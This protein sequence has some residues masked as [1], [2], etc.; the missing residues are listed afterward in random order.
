MKKAI[1]L[2]S[3]GLIGTQ[4]TQL[5]IADKRYSEIIILVRKKTSVVH[6]KL[7]QI[8]YDFNNG[9]ATHFDADEIYCCLGTTIKTAGSKENFYKVDYTYVVES[10]ML[11]KKSCKQ[12]AVISSMGA[13][14][15]SSNFYSKTKG[16]MES[17]VGKLH[18]ETSCIFRP[19]LLLGNRKEFRLGEKIATFFMTRLSFAIPLKYKAITDVLVAKSMVHFM[20]SNQKGNYVIE[21][22]AMQLMKKQ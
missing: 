11:A 19:S 12:F 2:G 16:E 20:N 14:E 21:S 17:A 3:T 10:A 8:V 7:T 9:D 22:D 6:T 18:F 13:S 4:L 1:V 15:T 5:L